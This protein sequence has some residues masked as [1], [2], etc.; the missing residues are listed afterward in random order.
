MGQFGGAGGGGTV[1]GAG[2][3]AW[4]ANTVG[5]SGGDGGSCSDGGGGGG[6]AL[7]GSKTLATAVVAETS[8]APAA[9]TATDRE[10][11]GVR[12]FATVAA[13]PGPGGTTTVTSTLSGNPRQEMK[14]PQ[15][16][17]QDVGMF[18]Q[19]A[20]GAVMQYA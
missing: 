9:L 1:S 8:V 2:Q 5:G 12:A 4:A 3:P 15:V 18:T 17:G 19:L 16:V 11:T 10:A 20:S 7:G 14:G 6:G 13:A